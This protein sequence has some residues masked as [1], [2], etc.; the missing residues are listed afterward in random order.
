MW[1]RRERLQAVNGYALLFW[2]YLTNVD[3]PADSTDVGMSIVAAARITYLPNMLFARTITN[4][5]IREGE[6][7]DLR[8]VMRFVFVVLCEYL[9]LRV[10]NNRY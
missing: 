6:R 8:N 5:H 10:V 7:I 1:R 3:V 9:S 4:A 2:L